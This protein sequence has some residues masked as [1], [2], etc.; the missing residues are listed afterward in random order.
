MIPP[1][2]FAPLTHGGDLDAARRLFPGAPEPWLDLSTGINPH[3]YPIPEI[4]PED[5]ARLPD[6]EGL[7]RLTNLAATV[8]AA[9][10]ESNL[11]PAPGSQILMTLIAGLVP[12]G[13]AVILGPTYAEHAR[14]AALAGHEVTTVS[15]LAPLGEA[16]LAVA[17]N[18]NNPDGRLHGAREL[19]RVAEAQR[20]RNGLLVVDE[21]FMDAS[22]RGESLSLDVEGANVVV[23]RSFGKFFGLAG[24]RLSFALAAKDLAA[25]LRADLG[26]WPVSGPAL[27]VGIEALSDSRWIAATRA[28]LGDAAQRLDGL[29]AGA[30]L[31][32]V[33]GTE[34][35]HLVRSPDAPQV[36]ERLGRSGVLVRRFDEQPDWLR[37]GLPGKEEAW[38]RL[39]AALRG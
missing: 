38:Q 31:E 1:N 23:L 4:S 28:S 24:I 6:A 3:P 33:G 7:A 19:R 18:P 25:R 5:F 34:L 27:A 16:D 2:S 21:A 30:G 10:S 32:R 13:R 17:V 11:V 14:V 22:P 12:P 37:F 20:A 8:Y 29:L 39:E 26:P 15:E 35:F 9:P 36:F